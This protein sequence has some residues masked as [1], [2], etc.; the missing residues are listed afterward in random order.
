MS[1]FLRIFLRFGCALRIYP[2]WNLVGPNSF[3]PVG[4]F[5]K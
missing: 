1:I 3:W 2:E 4:P 5:D